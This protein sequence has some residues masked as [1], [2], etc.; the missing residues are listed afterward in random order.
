[1][2]SASRP[3]PVT[4][5]SWVY[6]LAREL[7][8]APDELAHRLAERHPERVELGVLNR[9]VDLLHRFDAGPANGTV[10]TIVDQ[11]NARD[12]LHHDR[13]IP[14]ILAHRAED[15]R[16]R[17][18]RVEVVHRGV[19]GGRLLLRKGDDVDRGLGGER[20]GERFGERDRLGPPDVERHDDVRKEDGAPQGEERPRARQIRDGDDLLGH[21]VPWWAAATLHTRGS[22]PHRPKLSTQEG[23][24]SVGDSDNHSTEN[25]YY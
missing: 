18:D 6:E 10:S 8:Q 3:V 24:A 9:H 17:P 23:C 20:L 5:P 21:D 16:Q 13:V 2:K 11:P 19:V 1:M 25:S 12:P 14:V 15:T 22:L 4:A 7:R